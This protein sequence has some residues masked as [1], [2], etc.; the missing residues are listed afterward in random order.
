[1]R[2]PRAPVVLAAVACLC[3]A[4]AWAVDP[5]EIQVYQEELQEPFQ[6]GLEVHLNT[7]PRGRTAPEWSGELPPGGVSRV[8]LEPAVGLTKWLELGGY[9][10]AMMGPSGALQYGGFKLRAKLILP[11]EEGASCRVGVN[12][13]VGLVP[14]EVEQAG[15]ANE[16]RP[17]ALCK[18]GD[19]LFDVNPIVGI[20]LTGPE[21]FQPYFEPAG[22]VTWN[23]NHGFGLGV[24]YY[25]G[26]GLFR[27]A[28]S[29]PQEHLV[30]GTFDLMPPHWRE[31]EASAWELNVGV[32]AGLTP[33]TGRDL[34]VKAIVGRSF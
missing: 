26:L 23:S 32:G 16:F 8:T 1:M 27:D 19:F 24:E 31:D 7:V 21:A 17:I 15:W 12:V 14:R 10:Q 29:G 5:F 22:K 4:R 6:A 13:E 9:L 25:A 30:F 20:T 18:A 33:A 3:G 2:L 34:M 28:F 11:A